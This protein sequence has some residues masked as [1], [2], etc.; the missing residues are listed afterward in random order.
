MVVKLKPGWRLDLAQA[1]FRR[2]A[3]QVVPCLPAGA[4]LR[5]ALSIDD[6]GAPT[7]AE[8]ELARFVHLHWPDAPSTEDALALARSWPCVERA[9]PRL[10]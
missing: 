7:P 2:R 6:A 8:R 9:E 5:P 3:Q 4:R 1:L 10:S